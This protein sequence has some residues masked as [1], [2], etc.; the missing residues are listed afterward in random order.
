MRDKGNKSKKAS[1]VDPQVLG[2]IL[3]LQAALHAIPN[4]E[5]LAEFLSRGLETVPGTCF[6][7]VQIFPFVKF[8]NEKNIRDVFG[9]DFCKFC[10]QEMTGENSD[11]FII[12]SRYHENCFCIRIQTINT[13]YGCIFFEK[14]N[15]E[16]LEPYQPFLENLAYTVALTLEIRNHE[17]NLNQVNEELLHAKDGLETLVQE[18]TKE[19]LVRNEELQ[20][21]AHIFEHAEWGVTVDTADGKTLELIN[22]AFARMHGYT[23]DELKGQSLL[24]VFA[25]EV[26]ASVPANI[27]LAHEKGHHIWE[28]VD[29]RKDG[30]RFPVLL[31]VTAV[32]DEQGEVL[33]R[34]INVQDITTRKRA[35]ESIHTQLERLNALHNID[36]AIK[37]SN[38]LRTTLKTFLGEVI[39]Q[40]KIDAA[41]VLLFNRDTLTLDYAAN[42]GF[43]SSVMQ[44]TKLGLGEGFAGRVI[45]DGKTIFVP[46]L[47]KTENR[48]AE[49]LSLAGE[50]FTAYVGFPVITKGQVVGVLEIFHRSPLSV[51]TSWFDFL[52]TLAGQAA[53]A[54][55]N[56][57]LFEN[58]QRSNFELTIAYDA[59][60]EGWSRALDLR[61]RET[62]GHTQRVTTLTMK[63]A[64]QMGIPEADLLHIRRG[65]LLH[66]IGKMGIPDNILL[67]PDKLTPEE[68]EKMKQ[69][70][71]Y[72]YEM[73]R[74]I[75]YLRPALD[76]PRYHHE[77]WDG[78]GYPY[79]LKGQDIPL[80]ARIFSIV[81]VWDA[82]TSDRP[83][84][85]AWS[86][87]KALDYIRSEI[88]KAF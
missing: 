88:G 81:D 15:Q 83:Y 52:D 7:A 24:S 16:E 61:D 1:L 21:W 51:D 11:G 46:D 27:Q 63:L 72:A 32:R 4:S 33:Y 78:T 58:L 2:K 86:K 18:R 47:T 53:I 85:G 76:I 31:D 38:D 19:L 5:N 25:P 67:K 36:Y 44:Y 8:S 60:I 68:W 3:I 77:K 64:L 87:E 20:R 48:L 23:V 69:H 22:P 26:R 55:D 13:N 62:E 10:N 39:A 57:R 29:L 42:S 65:A 45:I 50:N 84:R 41:S 59:T 34:V 70:T 40:L 74:P 17:H 66:D 14:T 43:R 73:L 37:S 79:Q 28:S 82:I 56:A 30:E 75:A 12:P 6:V 35:E 9:N 71:I 80:P 49:V 54:I